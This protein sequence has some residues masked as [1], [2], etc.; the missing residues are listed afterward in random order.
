MNKEQK[1]KCRCMRREAFDINK[2]GRG[3]NE[4]VKALDATGQHMRR[5]KGLWKK[6]KKRCEEVRQENIH[7]GQ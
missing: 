2:R 6:K 7:F 3:V 5:E 4:N 1:V